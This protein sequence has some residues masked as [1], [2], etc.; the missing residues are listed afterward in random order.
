MVNTDRTIGARISGTI[1]Q[2]YGNSG[3]GGHL[4]LKFKG[5]AGQSFGAFNLPG[6][7]LTLEG[8]SNDYVGKGM[9]GGTIVIHPLG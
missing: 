1:A 6:M 4:S 7:T 9:H 5:S 8:E 3:F 2:Q